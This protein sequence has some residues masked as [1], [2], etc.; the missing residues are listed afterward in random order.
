MFPASRT[1]PECN[2]VDSS[3]WLEYL[4][5][6]PNATYFAPAIEETAQLIVPV[7]CLYEVYKRVYQ[8]RDEGDALRCIALMQQGTVVD[9]DSALSLEA[10]A[11][12]LT[13]RLPTADSL[14][15]ATAHRNSALL[16]TQDSDF[17]GLNGVN[18]RPAMGR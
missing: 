11:I 1:V 6:G 13:H 15:L 17:E 3:A 9:L 14:I 16:W 4:A 18:Y 10:A 12:S 2:V 5:D 7:I 8:R